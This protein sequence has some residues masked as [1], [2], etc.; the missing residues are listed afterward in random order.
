MNLYI[1]YFGIWNDGMDDHKPY[2]MECNDPVY[3]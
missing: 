1:R 3:I 2:T